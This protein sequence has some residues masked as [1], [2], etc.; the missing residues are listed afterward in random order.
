MINALH[1]SQQG[2]MKNFTLDS[3][4]FG[5]QVII[6]MLEWECQRMANG[7]AYMVPKLCE[8]HYHKRFMDKCSTS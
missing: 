5:W 1:S 2:G 4:Q 7:N 3:Q 8:T 6:D